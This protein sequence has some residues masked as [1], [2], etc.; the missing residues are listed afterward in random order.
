MAASCARLSNISLPSDFGS[1]FRAS[2]RG[3]PSWRSFRNEF[4]PRAPGLQSDSVSAAPVVDEN[5][6]F[7]YTYLFGAVT[8]R[9]SET[10]SL[11]SSNS[12]RPAS[13]N[14]RRAIARPV[15][16]RLLESATSPSFGWSSRSNK[17]A[18][19]AGFDRHT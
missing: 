5:W 12:G 16:M 8:S 6:D 15:R 9:S 18:R 4:T 7:L 3:R 14:V 10:I 13:I 19:Q 2:F 1:Q 11:L 17:T